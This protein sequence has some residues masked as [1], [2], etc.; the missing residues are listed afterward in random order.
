M[1]MANSKSKLSKVALEG[2]PMNQRT[3]RY[4]RLKGAIQVLETALIDSYTEP[5]VASISYAVG[6]VERLNTLATE[7]IEGQNIGITRQQIDYSMN[8]NN[9][10]AK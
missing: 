4:A 2:P 10:E 7:Y 8:K 1:T 6:C 9:P 5:T 3:L